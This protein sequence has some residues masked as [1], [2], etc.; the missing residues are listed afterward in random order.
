[1]NKIVTEDDIF[2]ILAT[3]TCPFKNNCKSSCLNYKHCVIPN[4]KLD[5]IES[6][7]NEFKKLHNLC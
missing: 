3:V 2:P 7:I 1:M 6:V 4:N 5:P